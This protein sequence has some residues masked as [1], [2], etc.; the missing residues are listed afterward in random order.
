MSHLRDYWWMIPV[1]LVFA[2]TW[3]VGTGYLLYRH[4]RQQAA[5]APRRA[6]PG[7]YYVASLLSCGGC[8]LASGALYYLFLVIGRS[9]HVH[10][11]WLGSAFA[12]LAF[13][14]VGY[15]VLYA[16]LN[17]PP[18]QTLG[19]WARSLAICAVLGVALGTPSYLL[20][21]H[22]ARNHLCDRNIATLYEGIKECTRKYMDRA[23]ANRS[24]LLTEIPETLPR[25]LDELPYE[26]KVRRDLTCPCAD[27]RGMGYF[28]LPPAS[29]FNPR[30]PRQIILCDFRDNHGANNRGVLFADGSRSRCADKE[31]QELLARPENAT[32]AAGLRQAEGQ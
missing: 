21:R 28:Y 20:F 17:L 16:V 32:F 26:P 2:A 19:L 30:V 11:E 4:A 15:L 27:G 25:T 23:R 8:V 10:I 12:V 14:A 29:I 18:R 31:F 22:I 7:R 9:L 3:V 1:A 6:R 13:L 24:S 5:T